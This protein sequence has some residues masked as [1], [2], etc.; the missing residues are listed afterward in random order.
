MI[1]GQKCDDCI[2]FWVDPKSQ[3][4]G[5][6][7]K[8]QCRCDPPQVVMLQL[9]VP[10]GKIGPGNVFVA[11]TETVS[12]LVSQFPPMFARDPGCGKFEPRVVSGIARRKENA[13]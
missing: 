4:P 3:D 10:A 7:K 6:E 2:H 8:G 5:D 1:N 12:K 11:S 9:K 13:S